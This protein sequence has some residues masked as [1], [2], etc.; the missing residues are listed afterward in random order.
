MSLHVID[1]NS[2]VA[3]DQRRKRPLCTLILSLLPREISLPAHTYRAHVQHEN[4][5]SYTC[6]VHHSCCF[7]WLLLLCVRKYPHHTPWSFSLSL[8]SNLHSLPPSQALPRG[9]GKSPPRVPCVYP[10]ACL[11]VRAWHV[12]ICVC[13]CVYV[14][15]YLGVCACICTCA[16]ACVSTCACVCL[17]VCMCACE[18][19][20]SVCVHICVCVSACVHACECQAVSSPPIHNMFPGIQEAARP[21]SHNVRGL[22]MFVWVWNLFVYT[23]MFQTCINV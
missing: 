19:H 2:N 12:Y 5:C 1:E 16:C 8:L 21:L 15:V 22:I 7:R 3:I 23:R 11:R 20:L 4:N 9:E 17:H 10:R 6:P 18:Y 13:A 14:R